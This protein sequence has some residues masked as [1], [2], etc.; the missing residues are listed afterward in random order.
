MPQIYEKLVDNSLAAALSS[1]EIYN[2]PDFKYREE[3]FTILIIN[4]WELLMKAKI[5][6]DANDDVTSLYVLDRQGGYKQTRNGTPLTIE[7][8]GAINQ[9][10]LAPVVAENIK[11]LVEIRDTAIH[12]Y[13]DQPLSYLLYTLAGASLQNYQKLI[14]SWFSKDLLEYNFYILPLGFAYNF[15]TL[16]LIDL[17]REPDVI[18]KLVKSVI[19]MQS[20]VDQSSEFYFVCEITTQIKKNV[21]YLADADLSVV[22]N[23]SAHD[24]VII[25][26]PVPLIEQYP[27]SYTELRNRVKSARPNTK[28]TLIDKVIREKKIKDN[29]NMSAYNFRTKT[30]KD[31][32]ERTGVLPKDIT[33]IYNENAVRFIIAVLPNN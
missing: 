1:I 2:K 10:G 23:P 20:S 8:T 19:D 11:F 14:N 26:R 15:K 28:Q 18:T 6:L 27:F 33:S 32:W 22:I 31:K 9:V 4:A 16:S 17:E 13:H 24:A 30:Q 29:S 3:I 7:I 5:L 21:Q 12:F 25:D